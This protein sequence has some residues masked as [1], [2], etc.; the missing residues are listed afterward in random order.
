MDSTTL[1]S[2]AL[3][4]AGTWKFCDGFSGVEYVI[5]V[6]K[7]IPAVR[8]IDTSD[9]ESAEVMDISW[10]ESKLQL[11]FAVHWNHGRL[12]RYRVSVGPRGDRVEA[13]ITSTHQELWERIEG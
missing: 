8:V 13:T 6:E 12:C 9:G 3:R 1:P 7:G 4:I 2:Q 5:T 10:I 11:S